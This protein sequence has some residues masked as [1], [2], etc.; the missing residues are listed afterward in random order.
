MRAEEKRKRKRGEEKRK[1]RVEEMVE[2][3]RRWRQTRREKQS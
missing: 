2:T 3:Q 1:K